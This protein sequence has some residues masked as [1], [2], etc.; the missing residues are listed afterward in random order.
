M[1]LNDFLKKL[2]KTPRRWKL[3]KHYGVGGAIRSGRRCPVEIV[4][5]T[6]SASSG[7]AASRL[8]LKTRTASRI[9]H[10]ADNRG[11]PKLRARLL[12]ACGL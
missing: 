1:T 11:D 8:G 3:R 5:G 7:V 6:Q 9:F 2:E 12:R 4:A 10:A